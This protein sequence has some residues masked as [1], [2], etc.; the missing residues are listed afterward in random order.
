[1]LLRVIGGTSAF[2]ASALLLT[3]CF[4][5]GL[6]PDAVEVSGAPAGSSC[7]DL[8]AEHFGLDPDSTIVDPHD[9][10]DSVGLGD[11]LD[12]ACAYGFE[13]DQLAAVAFHI[14]DPSEEEAA[15]YFDLAESVGAGGGFLLDH[16]KLELEPSVFGG[17]TEDGV[18]FFLS[19]FEEFG[20]DDGISD[21][22]F[23]DMGLDEG[24]PLITGGIAVPL[25]D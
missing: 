12:G 25:A 19:Y 3:G 4:G 8:G 24:H 1:M 23:A 20:L 6:G 5:A 13:T 18:K 15:A 2:A 22:Q 9:V 14:P 21:E 11:L 17:F 10:A 16:T 7:P